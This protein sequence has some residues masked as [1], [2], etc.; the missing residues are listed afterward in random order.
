MGEEEERQAL[1]P[2]SAPQGGVSNFSTQ[3]DP[4]QVFPQGSLVGIPRHSPAIT[5]QGLAASRSRLAPLAPLRAPQEPSFTEPASSS[6]APR[7]AWRLEKTVPN[8]TERTHSFFSEGFLLNECLNLPGAWGTQVMF[9][10]PAGGSSWEQRAGARSRGARCGVSRSHSPL[11][12]AVTLVGVSCE[13]TDFWP[14]FLSCSASPPSPRGAGTRC[15]PRGGAGCRLQS[16]GP[17]AHRGTRRD[18]CPGTL[19]G[20]M[21]RPQI[22]RQDE[23]GAPKELLGNVFPKGNK[24]LLGWEKK[25]E[26][27]REQEENVGDYCLRCLGQLCELERSSLG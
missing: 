11:P 7:P 25:K 26:R 20:C 19:L 24:S 2:T 10:M 21:G 14:R 17:R 5:S 1:H 8:K 3:N 27:K 22:G 12:S 6:W 9:P 23:A 13:Q 15:V 18:G 16:H 4:N